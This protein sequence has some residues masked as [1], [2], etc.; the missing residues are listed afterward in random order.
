MLGLRTAVYKV[1]NL[2][3]ATTWYRQAFNED[4]YFVQDFYVG[5]NIKGFELGLLPDEP[6][7]RVWSD[8]A[9]SYW[10]VDDIEETYK[11]LIGVGA[12]EH[13]APNSVGGNLMVASVYDPWG[14]VIGIIYN[15]EFKL[16]E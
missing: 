13:E 16:P 8:N 3:L 9:V 2:E 10:G 1:P 7:D 12:K 11:H 6:K 4:P 15:P 14:N 5:F